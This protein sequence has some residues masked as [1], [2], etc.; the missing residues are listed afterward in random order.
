MAPLKYV[1]LKY[2]GISTNFQYVASAVLISF[3]GVVFPIVIKYFINKN[4]I[5]SKILLGE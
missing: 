1:W 5:L 4:K 3:A 2:I